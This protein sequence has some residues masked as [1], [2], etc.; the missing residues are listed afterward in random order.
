MAY[1]FLLCHPSSRHDEVYLS[2][3]QPSLSRAFL[4]LFVLKRP[5]SIF[6]DFLVTVLGFTL[7][8]RLLF[9]V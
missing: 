1:D 7:S 3:V 2:I 5:D 8:F 6:S 9:P 4:V